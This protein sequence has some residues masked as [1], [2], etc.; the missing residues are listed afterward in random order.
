[1]ETLDSLH[2]ACPS[3]TLRTD[4]ATLDAAG[5][6]AMRAS[7]GR[8]DL[9]AVHARPLAVAEP[10]STAEVVAL[11]RWAGRVH[12]A[13]VPRG[14]GSGLMG[15]AAVLR[16]AVVLDLRRLDGVT[17]DA[18]ACLVT[19][20]AGATFARVDAALAGHKYGSCLYQFGYKSRLLRGRRSPSPLAETAAAV[21]VYVRLSPQF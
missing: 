20:G 12:T 8:P 5:V 7:R 9:L 18:D 14:G 10:A 4:A 1:M 15:G 2:A 13:I 16:P 6:D 17:V 21:R 3:L 11:V 19:A